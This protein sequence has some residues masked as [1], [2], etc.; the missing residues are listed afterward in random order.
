MAPIRTP[1]LVSLEAGAAVRGVNVLAGLVDV[2]LAVVVM[3]TSK[4]VL[5][6]TTVATG[7]GVAA[8]LPRRMVVV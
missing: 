7:V 8:S 2:M 6:P 4:I 5:G 3:G 1:L